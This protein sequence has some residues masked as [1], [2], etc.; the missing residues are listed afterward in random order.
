MVEVLKVAISK[1]FVHL[2]TAER[3]GTEREVGMA[4]R[5]SGAPR[6]DVFVTTKVYQNWE[7]VEA[8]VQ[9]SLDKLGMDY[10]DL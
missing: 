8:A 10:I 5:E 9:G 1:G 6:R 3:Y 7:N 4:V 2:D